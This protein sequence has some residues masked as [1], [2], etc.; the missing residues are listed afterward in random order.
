MSGKSARQIPRKTHSMFVSRYS[1]FG[2]CVSE[3]IRW[4]F[5]ES[6]AGRSRDAQAKVRRLIAVL[7]RL[8]NWNLL[9]LIVAVFSV[10]TLFSSCCCFVFLLFRCSLGG[11]ASTIHYK[12]MMIITVLRL[13][14]VLKVLQYL[15]LSLFI[16][17][18]SRLRRI[19][20]RNA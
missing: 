17:F 6:E 19:L 4:R 12:L 11:V 18:V 9:I 13:Y 3:Q 2:A 15:L 16:H 14:R 10:F 1:P 7:L 5:A 8:L 20:I